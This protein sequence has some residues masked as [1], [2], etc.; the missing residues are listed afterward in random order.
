M[1]T[2]HYLEGYYTPTPQEILKKTEQLQQLLD[3][4]GVPLKVYPGSEVHIS[5]DLPELVQQ[6]KVMTVNYGGKY[7][8]VELP[9]R[10]IPLY[11]QEVL[12]RLKLMGITPIIAHPERN[13]E[14][15]QNVEQL[16]TL[17]QKGCL[18]QVNAQSLLGGYGGPI[19]KTAKLLA[20]RRITHFVGSDLHNCNHKAPDHVNAHGILESC[21]GNEMAYLV[22]QVW[23]HQV[24]SGNNLSMDSI[25]EEASEQ[26]LVSRILAKLWK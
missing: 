26:G 19:E 1:A 13:E 16:I 21:C 22:R 2:P 12:F 20:R 10:E 8:L 4:K 7:L 5:P 25:E 18:V 3:Q 24:V 14:V 17:T 6:G 23:A 11:T 9:F 15:I